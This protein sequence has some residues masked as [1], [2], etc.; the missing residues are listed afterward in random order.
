[1]KAPFLKK[2][3]LTILIFGILI[4]LFTGL[5]F[6]TEETVFEA[7]NL[8]ITQE[9]N[10]GLNWSPLIGVAVIFLGG[11]IYVRGVRKVNPAIN[12]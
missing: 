3:G 7:G 2:V 9:K 11:L 10:H 4:T 12:S 6:V 1:M 5:N 8:N